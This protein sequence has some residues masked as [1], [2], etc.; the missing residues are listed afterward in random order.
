MKNSRQVPQNAQQLILNDPVLW[1]IIKITRQK[2]W[3]IVLLALA[4]YG[5]AYFGLGWLVSSHSGVHAF[6]SMFSPRELLP[7][8]INF[9]IVGPIIWVY[10]AQESMKITRMFQELASRSIFGTIQPDGKPVHEFFQKQILVFNTKK[11]FLL[12]LMVIT[13]ITIFLLVS[14]LVGLYDPHNPWR[15]GKLP[16]WFEL[17]RVYFIGIFLPLTFLIYYMSLWF[18]VR[19]YIAVTILN[20]ALNNFTMIPKLLDPDKANGLSPVGH[21]VTKSAPLMAVYGFWLFE[22]FFYPTFFGQPITLNLNS[23]ETF[24]VYLLLAPL[25]LYLP[26]RKLHQVMS[27]RR[28]ER[29]D[30]VAEQIRMR[31]AVAEHGITFP[32]ERF[33]FSEIAPGKLFLRDKMIVPDEFPESMTT[34]D[35]LYRK[36]QLLEKEY[37]RWPFRKMEVSNYIFAIALP[38]ILSLIQA[39]FQIISLY[40]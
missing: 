33:F 25:V 20:R 11:R 18:F 29:L 14:W 17:N 7:I 3:R 1:G 34:I 21:Y 2:T 23:I 37:R 8:I 13:A 22:V 9:F 15:I 38:L 5:G 19:R 39:I 12:I 36:Y 16:W 26:V 6:V 4:V 24:T 27:E 31:I 30:A 40:K 28:N 35:S 10:Y 32:N